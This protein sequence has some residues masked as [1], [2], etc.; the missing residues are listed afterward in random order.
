MAF[1]MKRANRNNLWCVC[2]IV[3]L[4]DMKGDSVDATLVSYWCLCP[5][6]Y[7]LNIIVVRHSSYY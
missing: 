1:M 3:E 4:A 7:G 5:L 2:I 6:Q